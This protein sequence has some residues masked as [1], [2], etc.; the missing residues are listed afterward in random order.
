[1]KE[2]ET[3]LEKLKIPKTTI[4]EKYMHHMLRH[5]IYS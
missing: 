1:M 4:S 3:T 2:L 5:R